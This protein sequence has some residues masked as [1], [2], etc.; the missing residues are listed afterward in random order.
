MSSSELDPGD[1][2]WMLTSTALVLTMS[3]ALAF[4]QAGL[5]RSKNTLSIYT[6]IF[7]G[8]IVLCSLWFVVGYSLTFGESAAVLGSPVQHAL[9]V[10]VSYT[11]PSVHAPHVPAAVFALFQ[12]M[13]ACITPLLITGA[14][15]ERLPFRVFLLFSVLFS[16]T[17]Y[18]PVAHCVWGGGFLDRLGVLDFAGHQSRAA[19]GG[20]AGGAC[21]AHSL[22]SPSLC[23]C[24]AQ[25]ASRSTRLRAWP[26]WS[27]LR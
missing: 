24:V 2:S 26:L 10:D 9:F 27:P 25:A 15:A 6:Q 23:C 20:T 17:V 11:E 22:V 4:F 1:T 5:L 8:L 13:F 19:G 16:L 18:Y 3:P 21:T 12:M 14:Y 7:A